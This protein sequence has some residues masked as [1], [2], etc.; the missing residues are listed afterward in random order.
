MCYYIY[1]MRW[2]RRLRGGYTYKKIV[3][4]KNT[5][6]KRILVTSKK[7]KSLKSSGRGKSKKNRQ[8]H[9]RKRR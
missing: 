4:K 5:I 9:K 6:R 2:L 1:I 7:S 3:G 8:G